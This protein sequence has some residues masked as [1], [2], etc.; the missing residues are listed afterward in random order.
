MHG[1]RKAALALLLATLALV[2]APATASAL[3]NG[4]GNGSI[5]I[6]G[7]DESGEFDDGHPNNEP[8]LVGCQFQIDTYTFDENDVATYEF[9]QIG[10]HST[11]D[12]VLVITANPD[13]DVDAPELDVPEWD[14]PDNGDLPGDDFVDGDIPSFDIPTSDLDN[15]VINF[16]AVMEGDPHPKHGYHVKVDA[17]IVSAD[18]SESS[19]SKVFWTGVCD[20]ADDVD[21]ND[22][23]DFDNDDD[24]N[25]DDEDDILIIF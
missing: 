4:N 15:S 3:G 12:P 19:H 14:L 21:V 16:A 7:P 5:K 23:D 22:D 24:V 2:L 17:T 20:P 25:N 13:E 9:R 18:G 8:H 1:T 11:V 10:K 6:D